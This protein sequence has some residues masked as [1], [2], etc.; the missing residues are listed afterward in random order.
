MGNNAANPFV[1]S[2]GLGSKQVVVKNPSTSYTVLAE[3]NLVICG[4]NSLVITLN[5]SSNSPVYITSIDGVTQRTGCTILA[6]VA[7][8]TVDYVLADGGCTAMCVRVGGSGTEWVVVG[9]KTAS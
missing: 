9:A 6:A 1:V 5:S 3:D 2:D 7:A 8:G 4:A